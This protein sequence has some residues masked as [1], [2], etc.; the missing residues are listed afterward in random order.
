MLKRVPTRVFAPATVSNVAVGFDILG[1]A[2]NNLGD[3]VKFNPGKEPGLVIKA[4]HYNKVLS[5]NIL[6]N[7]ASLSAYK[8]L[9]SLGLEDEPIEMELYKNMDIGTG[10]GSSASS[11]VAGAFGINEYLGRPYTKKQLLPFVTEAEVLADGA[12]HADNVAPSLLGSFI[13]IRD[14]KTLDYIKLPVIPGL[15]AVIVHPKVEVLTKHSRKLLKTT[16]GLDLHVQQS[17]NLAAFI[18][19]LYRSDL[20]LLKRSLSDNII[21]SQRA[22]LIPEFYNIKSLAMEF[23]ALGCSISGSGPT[24]FCLCM[25]SIIADKIAASWTRHYKDCGIKCDVMVSDINKE[26]AKIC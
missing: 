16:I 22:H 19:S 7:T 21:E 6:E 5:K 18:A 8:V 26:G 24:I 3:E 20:P 17:G 23:G 9:K 25:N 2:I 4:I 12:Y 1:F 13:L 14:N 10:L 15:K 11:A